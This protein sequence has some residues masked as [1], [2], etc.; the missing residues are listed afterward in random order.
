MTRFIFILRQ[1]MNYSMSLTHNLVF[2]LMS[3]LFLNFM[4]AEK[5]I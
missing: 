4:Q 3:R 2:A 1:S 5:F